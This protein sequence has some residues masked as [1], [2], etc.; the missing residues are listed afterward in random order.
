MFLK[1][2]FSLVPDPDQMTEEQRA[3]EEERRRRDAEDYWIYTHMI[4]PDD[5]D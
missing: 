4:E 3:A 2:L 5:D 1:W